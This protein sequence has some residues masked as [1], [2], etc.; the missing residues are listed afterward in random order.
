MK[1]KRKIGHSVETEEKITTIFVTD[2]ELKTQA[3]VNMNKCVPSIVPISNEQ[4]NGIVVVA[5]VTVKCHR[6]CPHHPSKSANLI[7]FYAIRC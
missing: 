7:G 3:R 1:L 2:P 5:D 6:R 4:L